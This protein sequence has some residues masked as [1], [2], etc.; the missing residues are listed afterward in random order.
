MRKVKIALPKG[1]LQEKT[2]ELFKEAGFRISAQERSYKLYINDEELEPYLLRPQEIPVYVETG[3]L[4]CGITGLDWIKENDSD[5]LVL[6]EL[7]YAKKSYNKVRWVIAVRK[8]SNIKNLRDLEGKMISTELVNVTKKF[9]KKNKIKAKVEFSWGA[10]EAKV[11]AGFVDAIVELTETGESLKANNLKVIAEV[12]ESVT[13]F[14]VNKKVYK[15]DI[16]KKKKID[17]V[18]LLL[19]SALDAFNM[20]LIKMNVAKKNLEKVLKI[21][22]ALRKPT[23]SNLSEKDWLA[24]ETVVKRDKVKDLIPLLKEAGAQGIIEFSLNKLVY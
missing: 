8:D 24:I 4:D 1:S 6:G 9:L 19:K 18:Y 17:S 16:K 20:V 11:A 23:V 2:F 14:I 12:M 10:T 13:C 7:S 22:P 5:V 21:L 3:A 15:Q